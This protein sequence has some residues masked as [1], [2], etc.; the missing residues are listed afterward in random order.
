MVFAMNEIEKKIY[1]WTTTEQNLPI[2]R[3]NFI[4]RIIQYIQIH[5]LCGYVSMCL[6]VSVCMWMFSI[7]YSLSIWLY[8]AGNMYVYVYID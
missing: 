5:G 1:V 7:I 8:L 6:G 3:F 2:T 4:L